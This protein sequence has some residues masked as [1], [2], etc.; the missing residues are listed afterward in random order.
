M[1]PPRWKHLFGPVNS[2]RYGRSLGINLFPAKVC[3]ENCI[4]C[5]CGTTTELTTERREYVPTAEVCRELEL[6]LA[7]A[8]A[9]NY[10]TF[11]GAGE[12]LLHSGF[13]EIVHFLKKHFPA[14]RVCLL[15]NGTLLT[16]RAVWPEVARVDLV[17]PSLD[18]VTQEV[19]EQINRP[20][21]GTSASAIIDALREF[22]QQ[23]EGEIQLEVL[24]LPGVND[25]NAEVQ[26]IADACRTIR[27]TLV[28]VHT[29]DRPGTCH[30]LQPLRPERMA[31]L[32]RFFDTATMPTRSYAASAVESIDQDELRHRVIALVTL[33]PSTEEDMV[34]AIG[35]ER[36]SLREV[37]QTLVES[38]V[39]QR[40]GEFYR[41][42]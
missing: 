22:S 1:N 40:D 14:Y 2:R 8:P 33:R 35:A 10:I 41:G 9:L 5:E 32:A 37:L 20:A 16:D 11:A 30:E 24:L 4:Y 36:G 39:L 42:A 25:D 27:H 18:A 12:P 23:F 31:E 38:G 17:V 21:A 26:R 15:T 7:T 3:T 19:F 34:S 6:F 29:L 28:Q 13:G